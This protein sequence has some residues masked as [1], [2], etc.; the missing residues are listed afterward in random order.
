M[1]RATQ[2]PPS[3]SSITAPS[4]SSTV[5]TR[6]TSISATDSWT[7][8]LLQEL[9]SQ[10]RSPLP[11]CIFFLRPVSDARLDRWEAVLKGGVGVE[12]TGYECMLCFVLLCRDFWFFGFVGFFVFWFSYKKYDFLWSFNFVYLFG[13]NESWVRRSLFLFVSFSSL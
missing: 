4:S 10:S 3:S 9:K 5:P 2:A 6:A 12:G 1:S 13:E 7:K 11:A 8:R